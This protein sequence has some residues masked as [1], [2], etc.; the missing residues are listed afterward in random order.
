MTRSSA[1]TISTYALMAAMLAAGSQVVV[2]VVARAETAPPLRCT[3]AGMA[4]YRDP[5]FVS[6]LHPTQRDGSVRE[7]ACSVETSTN[8]TAGV[9]GIR[10]T[11]G[12][13]FNGKAGDA[14]LNVKL[15]TIEKVDSSGAKEIGRVLLGADP[16]TGE[17]LFEPQA[18]VAGDGVLIRISRRHRWIF[19]L[20]GN[21]LSA[22]TAFG[23]RHGLDQAFPDGAGDGAN[24]SIDL[25]GM[26]GRIAVR[27]RAD[28]PGTRLASAYGENRV[29]VAKL[30]WRN[31]KLVV[32]SSETTLRKRDEESFLDEITDQDEKIRQE[33]KLLP[34]GTEPCSLGAW[35]NDSDP[36]GL[37][38]RA[39]P[40]AKARVLG[41]VPPPRKLPP[42]QDETGSGPLKSE[43]RIIGYR[44]GWFLIDRI[45]AP[46]VT[47]GAPYPRALPQPYKGRGWV[48]TRMVGAAYAYGGLPN[49]NLFLSPHADA[50][51]SEIVD[52]NGNLLG[53]DGSPSSIQ[54]CTGLWGHVQTTGGQRGWWRTL[55]S[56]QVTNCS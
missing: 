31:D 32:E 25:E 26:T 53:P 46:G 4:L 55:C 33:L 39:E 6:S 30:A 44:D 13:L 3:V 14:V 50:G 10:L 27:A 21:S 54:A 41:I 28:M 15:V 20:Q 35:S 49:G 34:S 40:S 48:S 47:Y 9:A 51:S 45:A 29:V 5:V 23:W 56:N 12:R 16:L 2:P 24:L 22:E 37:N 19:R 43:F 8:M 11:L 38:V 7:V 36:K 17:M 42:E 52:Q 18:T 1:G